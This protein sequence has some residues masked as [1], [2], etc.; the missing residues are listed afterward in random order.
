MICFHMHNVP[1]VQVSI[2]HLTYKDYWE[3][4][5]FSNFQRNG[6]QQALMPYKQMQM[7]NPLPFPLLK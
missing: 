6:L 4:T 7:A 1:A 5:S 2:E 3:L